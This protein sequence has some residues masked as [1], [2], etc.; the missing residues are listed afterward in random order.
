M[1]SLSTCGKGA[2]A[3]ALLPW[4]KAGGVALD[5][6][7]GEDEF[8]RLALSLIVMA[9]VADGFG[10]EFGGGGANFAD[11]LMHGGERDGAPACHGDIVNTD[12]GHVLGY[13]QVHFACGIQRADG[14]YVV[15]AKYGCGRMIAAQ[16]L[17][18]AGIAALVGEV[19][20]EEF[21]FG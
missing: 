18:E 9:L 1:G 2:Q 7:G 20:V 10:Y 15:A 11:G 4:T 8:A 12:D 6:A 17:H 19:D 16:Q 3:G 21:I 13:A 5:Q 14:D